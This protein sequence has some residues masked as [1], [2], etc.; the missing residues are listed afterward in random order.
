MT[1][2]RNVPKMAGKMPPSV[3]PLRGAWRQEL[4]GD[5]PAALR[6]DVVEEEDEDGQDEAHGQPQGQE[7]GGLGDPLPGGLFHRSLS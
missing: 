4:P 7:A 5:R 3:M 1:V 6:A 2:T